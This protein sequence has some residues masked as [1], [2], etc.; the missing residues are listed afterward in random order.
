MGLEDETSELDGEKS[1]LDGVGGGSGGLPGSLKLGGSLEG[2]DRLVDVS[3]VDTNEL[4]R[5]IDRSLSRVVEEAAD[6]RKSRGRCQPTRGM[7]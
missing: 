5:A 6:L 1:R 4:G 7:V 3:I 2:V